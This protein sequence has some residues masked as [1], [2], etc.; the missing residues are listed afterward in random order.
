M[1]EQEFAIWLKHFTG[2]ENA[3]VANLDYP[4]EYKYWNEVYEGIFPH[5]YGF[6]PSAIR[7]AFPNESYDQLEYRLRIHRSMTK[8]ELWQ[9][10][11]DVKRIL[12]GDKFTIKTGLELN[13]FLSMTKFGSDKKQLPFEKY[14]WDIVYPRRVLDPNA[15]LAVIPVPSENQNESVDIDLRIFSH[16]DIKY[17][18]DDMVIV[19]DPNQTSGTDQFYWVFTTSDIL[20]AELIDN[21][22]T[23]RTWYTH[24]NGK[25]GV[26]FLGGLHMTMSDYYTHEDICYFESDFSYAVPIMDK[27]E[28]KDNQ[29]ESSTLNTVFP[30]RVTQGL[31]CETCKGKG[32][33]DKRDPI[34]GD[35]CYIDENSPYP[36]AETT[37]CKKCS[38]SGTIVLGALDGIVATPKNN[39]TFDD[40]A[41]N[42]GKIG[43][44]FVQYV[45]PDVSSIVELRTQE[46]D[47]EVRVSEVLNITK[48]SK[49][50][51]SGVAKEKDREGKFT[52]L[53]D[54]SD[55]MTALIWST[56]DT[57]IKYRNI[58]PQSRQAELESLQVLAPE[59]FQIRSVTELQDEYLKDLEK[60]PLSI[61][62]RQHKELL[63][64]RFKEEDDIHMLDDIAIAYTGG[65][66]LYPLDELEK[67]F[68]MG[69][70]T[71]DDVIRATRVSAILH[72]LKM[73]GMIT[74]DD[75]VQ[76][77]IAKL[78]EAFLPLLEVEE[79][80]T[81]AIPT[82]PI[83]QI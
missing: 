11:F 49:F 80:F 58:S 63:S 15:I 28:R 18:S 67:L 36:I 44:R 13:G 60:K 56:L 50:A 4:V 55:G 6:M 33:I 22:W 75:S 37:S 24:N 27:L 5:F 10:I 46:N 72:N 45:S 19:N 78:D 68:N 66:Y 29:L 8:S 34:T 38:G 79:E 76:Q 59:D 14:M 71:R 70:I 42:V 3:N 31:N 51:E 43:D 82:P 30:L 64:K 1:N 69:V 61:R 32:V 40:E 54:I 20:I 26:E 47:T 65:L 25:T 17:C 7:E 9:A 81:Q 73:M 39:D 74:M 62:I 77:I 21:Q 23:V 83:D 57:M 16:F 35:I 52:K 53:K 48:P 12:M 2:R 41:A